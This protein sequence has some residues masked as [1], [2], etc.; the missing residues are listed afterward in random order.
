MA[1][2]NQQGV[3]PGTRRELEPWV[4]KGCAGG[5][6]AAAVCCALLLLWLSQGGGWLARSL[7]STSVSVLSVCVCLCVSFLALTSVAEALPLHPT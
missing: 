4:V 5:A 7:Y 6:D 1:S 3:Q 2:R